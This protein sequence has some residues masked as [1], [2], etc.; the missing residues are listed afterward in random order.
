M[1]A[2]GAR[3]SGLP[4]R[5]GDETVAGDDDGGRRT[6]W[7]HCT[8]EEL[9]TLRA[10]ASALCSRW[11]VSVERAAE[12]LERNAETGRMEHVTW[13]GLRPREEGET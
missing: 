3:V 7:R 12:R 5:A 8:D 11:G 10:H 2:L 1:G 6:T 9:E 4:A 13:L